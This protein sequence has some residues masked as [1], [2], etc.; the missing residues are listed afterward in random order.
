MF[1]ILGALIMILGTLFVVWL[2]G[3]VMLFGGIVQ[4]IE[5]VKN[6]WEAV[7]IT[8][9]VLRVIFCE[10]ALIPLYIFYPLGIAFYKV[11]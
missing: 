2:G 11:K 6:N 3:Y 7:G 5:S 1:K 10:L 8:L 9:G 4:F